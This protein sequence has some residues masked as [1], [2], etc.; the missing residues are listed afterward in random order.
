[1]RIAFLCAPIADVGAQRAKLLRERTLPRYRIATE[2][3]DGSALNAA[4]RAIIGASLASH[5][6][7]TVAAFRRTFVARGNAILRCLIEMVAHD[8]PS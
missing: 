5:M 2:S 7:E 8:V 1:V 4:R 6:R 3:S